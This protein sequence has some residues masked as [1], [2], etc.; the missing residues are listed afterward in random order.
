MKLHL[1]IRRVLSGN[2]P[3]HDYCYLIQGFEVLVRHRGIDMTGKP[4]AGGAGHACDL[5]YLVSKCFF[6]LPI[7]TALCN[8]LKRSG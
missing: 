4:R 2:S 6:G 3:G 1:L 5:T 8:Q 7:H